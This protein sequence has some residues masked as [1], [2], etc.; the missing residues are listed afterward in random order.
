MGFF[1]WLFKKR[2]KKL[3]HD[4][5]QAK[6]F[7]EDFDPREISSKSKKPKEK[8]DDKNIIF[9]SKTM[10]FGGVLFVFDFVIV[11]NQKGMPR[12]QRDTPFLIS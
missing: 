4:D 3:G 6:Y 12:F 10:S 1:D 9:E 5:G 11:Q 8:K 2:T 7:K